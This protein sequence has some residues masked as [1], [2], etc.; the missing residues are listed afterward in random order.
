M[1]TATP[2]PRLTTRYRKRLKG[3]KRAK[4]R[5]ALAEGY[6]AGASIRAV[7][8][9]ADLSYGTARKLLLEAEVKLRGRGGSRSGGSR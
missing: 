5:Q 1:S 6:V 9:S 8:E 7:A 3:D 4:V 2:A